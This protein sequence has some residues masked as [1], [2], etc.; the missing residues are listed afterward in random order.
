MA[1]KY[2]LIGR[3]SNSMVE[4]VLKNRGIEN[5]DL[6]LNPDTSSHTNPFDIENMLRGV[7]ALCAH[8]SV[9]SKIAIIVDADADGFMS[10]T[11]IYQYL[12]KIDQY[13]NIDFIVHDKKTHGL[14]DE[15]MDELAKK[16]Y[17]LV[18]VPDAGS[19]DARQIEVLYAMGTEVLV[20]D[21]HIIETMP[22]F[23]IIVNNQ[24]G[25]KANKNLTGAGVCLKFV[26]AIDSVIGKNF[27]E[28]LYDLAAL[29]QIADVSNIA[30]NEVRYITLKGVKNI[31]NSFI[32]EAL[33]KKDVVMPVPRDLSFSVIPMINAIVRVGTLEEKILLFRALNNIKPEIFQVEKK[34]KNKET[35]KFDKYVAEMNLQ[36]Y[37]ADIA[38]KCKTRQDSAVKKEVAKAEENIWAEGGIAI[39]VTEVPEEYGALTG[40][41]ATKLV[42]KYQKPVI[43]L[44]NGEEK[45][46][47]SGRGYEPTLDNLKDWCQDTGHVVFAQGHE[48]AFGIEIDKE[49][50]E[51]F[52]KATNAITA[53]DFSYDVDAVF[54]GEVSVDPI[55]E[56]EKNK[57]IFGGKVTDALFAYENIEIEKK[58]ITAKGTVLTFYKN[59]L[60]F[61]MYGTT[62]EFQ[63]KFMDGFKPILN[64]DFIGRPSVNNWLG[65]EK[66]QIVL[67]AIDFSKE[68]EIDYDSIIF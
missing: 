4:T 8:L 51:D 27:A 50:F 10:S 49:N 5:I 60:E 23:G 67:D 63:A 68:K 21:H 44:R 19:N 29:G 25:E 33:A 36:Q 37:A 62:P 56:L 40:L 18:I 46:K 26:E 20:L 65:K 2:N 48:Q 24:L 53:R 55:W 30:E 61:V 3:A 1:L 31:K 34:R 12:K 59:G 47:G 52:K 17:E 7:Q 32:K 45:L 66:P 14:T 57:E 58:N 64:L 43:L 13:I 42:N 16:Q 22:D 11:I 39:A 15:I 54:E 35:G 6:F 41:I 38:V 9:N 28:D